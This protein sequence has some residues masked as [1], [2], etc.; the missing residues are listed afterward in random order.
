MQREGERIFFSF[1]KKLVA[2]MAKGSGYS[3]VLYLD[4]RVACDGDHGQHEVY[5]LS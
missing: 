4:L 3:Y 2:V 1:K 5:I